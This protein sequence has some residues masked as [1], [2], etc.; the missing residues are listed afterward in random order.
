MGPS[1]L[2]LPDGRALLMS[3]DPKDRFESVARFSKRD[4]E[5]LERWD[6]WLE[7]IGEV[8]GRAP[9]RGAAEG[10][11]QAPGATWSTSSGWPGS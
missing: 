1:Y 11:L 4:A 6:A 9:D 3:E 2:P 5:A 10:R 8:L 7:G